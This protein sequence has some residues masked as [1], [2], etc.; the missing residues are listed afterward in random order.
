MYKLWCHNVLYENIVFTSPSFA[1]FNNN[2]TSPQLYIQLIYIFHYKHICVLVILYTVYT[3]I[4]YIHYTYIYHSCVY[5]PR[6]PFVV[7]NIIMYI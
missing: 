6:P 3:N 5:S 1:V 4:H 2:N 7:H